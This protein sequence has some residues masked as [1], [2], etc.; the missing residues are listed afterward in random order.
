MTDRMIIVLYI[1]LG[2]FIYERIHRDA[3]R[4]R[5]SGEM[6]IGEYV[7]EPRRVE[8]DCLRADDIL[9]SAP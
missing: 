9:A 1:L 2:V 8:R 4:K 3:K 6:M 7:E 5:E